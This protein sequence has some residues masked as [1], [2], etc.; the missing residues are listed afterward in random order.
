M[1]PS[2]PTAAGGR[3]CTRT[4]CSSPKTGDRFDESRFWFL[5]GLHVPEP[6]Y[7]FDAM[8]FD[9]AVAR[10]QPGELAA[11]RR[12]A[13]ARRRVPHPQRVRLR[14][15]ELDH[16]RSDASRSEPSCS[17][18]RG[19]FYYRHWDELYARWLEKVE[20]AT[21]ELQALAVPELREVE[22]ESVVTE[23]EGVGSTLSPP[24]TP[25]TGCSRGSIASSST[26]S[27]SSTSATG[28]TSSST[29]SAATPSPT[30]PTRRSRRWFRG[31][32]SSC[33][34]RTTSFGGSPGCA[35]ELGVADDV[36]A[37]DQRGRARS[38]LGRERRRSAMARRLRADEGSVVLLL[39]RDRACSTTTTARGSTTRRSRSR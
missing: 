39:V 11:V 15:R 25:T 3:R 32:T 27:S 22:D 13:V 30:S 7:P 24:P 34:A 29:S 2:P 10:P 31:S 14:Q 26:T 33:S 19:G 5:E 8:T 35:V 38:C 17:R 36:D 12:S 6:L 4:T 28:R 9:A 1:C 23:G 20:D 37:R 16:G 21:K 18:R